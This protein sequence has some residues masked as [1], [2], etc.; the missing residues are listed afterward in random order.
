MKGVEELKPCPF[1]G[2]TDVFIRA[3][4]NHKIGRWYVFVQCDVCSASG[5]TYCCQGEYEEGDDSIW[6]DVVVDC[7]VRTWNR[8]AY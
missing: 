2:C 4:Y 8:R 1:C 6:N 7:A 5:K 3:K